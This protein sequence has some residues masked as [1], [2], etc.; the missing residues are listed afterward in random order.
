MLKIIQFRHV[1]TTFIKN[2]YTNV[3]KIRYGAV[4]M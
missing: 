1:S 2:I 3:F 4:F